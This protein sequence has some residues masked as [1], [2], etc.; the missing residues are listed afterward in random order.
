MQ[1][2]I[3]FRRMPLEPAPSQGDDPL[4]GYGE[5]SLQWI[6]EKKLPH[7]DVH[8]VLV[9]ALAVRLY[10]RHHKKKW[11]VDVE[12]TDPKT[13]KKVVVG[14]KFQLCAP[15]SSPSVYHTLFTETVV[16]PCLLYTSP[17]P[18]DRTRARMPS[19]A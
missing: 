3:D 2:S 5:E 8:T 6:V 1:N 18:R 14:S 15:P 12:K 7:L 13:K 16:L 19:S 17:S 4:V 10:V 11:I 9:Q